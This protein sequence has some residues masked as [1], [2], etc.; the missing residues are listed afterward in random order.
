MSAHA[1]VHLEE[2]DPPRTR[3]PWSRALKLIGGTVLLAAGV[4]MLVLPGPGIPAVIGG[5]WVLGD[6]VA[7]ARRARMRLTEWVARVRARAHV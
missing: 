1:L 4:A 7:W 6:D 5:L 2:P 3:N